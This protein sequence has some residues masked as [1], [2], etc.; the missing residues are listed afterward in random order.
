MTGRRAAAAFYLLRFNFT[1]VIFEEA[2]SSLKGSIDCVC[3]C[4]IMFIGC[5]LCGSMYYNQGIRLYVCI[6]VFSIET[7]P[8]AEPAGAGGV[9]RQVKE[10]TGSG[11]Y[12]SLWH[13]HT[14]IHTGAMLSDLAIVFLRLFIAGIKAGVGVFL[15][16]N[17]SNLENFDRAF[18][19]FWNWCPLRQEEWCHKHVDSVRVITLTARMTEV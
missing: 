7:S 18:E 8:W 9:Q 10:T 3:G 12:L 17:K 13:T 5:F 14:G 4:V 1:E 15:Y 11:E 6:C 19:K 2:H 16:T